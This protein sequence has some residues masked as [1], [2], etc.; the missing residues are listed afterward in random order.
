MNGKLWL[1]QLKEYLA[2]RQIMA[3]ALVALVAMLAAFLVLFREPVPGAVDFG[4]Y[5]QTLYEMGLSK[6]RSV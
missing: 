6:S 1:K 5:T 2:H 4:E 3:A